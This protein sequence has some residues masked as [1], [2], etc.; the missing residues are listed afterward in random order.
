MAT[1]KDMLQISDPGK[2]SSMIDEIIKDTKSEKSIADYRAGKEQA[3]MALVGQ[4]IRN[5]NGKANPTVTKSIFI[6]KLK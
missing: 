6:E 5:T 2:L 4:V 1:E 3:L